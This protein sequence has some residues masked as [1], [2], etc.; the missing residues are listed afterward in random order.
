MMWWQHPN[1]PVTMTCCEL[2]TPHNMV[3]TGPLTVGTSSAGRN[4]YLRR[5]CKPQFA[6]WVP[7]N[8]KSDLNLL[9]LLIFHLSYSQKI[10]RIW[11]GTT[12]ERESEEKWVQW[13]GSTPQSKS[14]A[15]FAIAIPRGNKAPVVGCT[16]STMLGARDKKNVV[17]PVSLVF[18]HHPQNQQQE[19]EVKNHREI[20][21][22]TSEDLIS[23]ITKEDRT[24]MAPQKNQDEYKIG[25][26]NRRRRLF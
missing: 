4:Y 12:H 25:G 15:V 13:Q 21:C 11:G 10:R 19:D 9:L 3:N 20:Y 16:M 1:I 18:T 26:I 8:L 17:I 2:Y 22:N 7:R 6:P 23:T 5:S 24:L 14:L